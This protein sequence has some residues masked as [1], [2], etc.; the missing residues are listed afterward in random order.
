MVGMPLFAEQPDNIAKAKDRG[1]ALSV[2]VKQ[3]QTLAKDLE[4]S[5]KRLLHEPSF[6]ENAARISHTMQA[7]RQTPLQVA[8]GMHSLLLRS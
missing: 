7:H 2:D 1:Y 5:L 3:I 8:G 4:R 6:G